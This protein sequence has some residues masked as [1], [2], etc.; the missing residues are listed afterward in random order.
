MNQDDG[1]DQDEPGPEKD[2]NPGDEGERTG[3]P[4]KPGDKGGGPNGTA[5]A[6]RDESAYSNRKVCDDGNRAHREPYSRKIAAGR[7]WSERRNL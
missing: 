6:P 4:S 3:R 1:D 2:G 7:A 5:I